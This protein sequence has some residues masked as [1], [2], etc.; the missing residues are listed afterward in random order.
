V[1]YKFTYANLWAFSI[2]DLQ[3]LLCNGIGVLNAN[4]NKTGLLSSRMINN[5]SNYANIS[6]TYFTYGK[7]IMSQV[8]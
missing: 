8:I 2:I 6:I 4:L 3:V 1:T 5:I 7:N